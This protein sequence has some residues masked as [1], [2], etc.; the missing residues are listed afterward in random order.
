MTVRP[1]PDFVVFE[2]GGAI[3]AILECKAANDGG[4]ARDKASR[5]KSLR[6]EGGRLGGV[7]VF[8]VLAG[9]GWKRT[10]DALG[11]VVEATD[12]RVFTL[13][14]IHEMVAVEPLSA[15]ALVK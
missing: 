13:A 14:T 12:G 2:P 3:R 9:L 8:A 15:L 6:A 10:G 7:P 4:A 5:F 1:A 11:P